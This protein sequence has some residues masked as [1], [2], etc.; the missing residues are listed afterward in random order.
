[1]RWDSESRS[2]IK[3]FTL[4]LLLSLLIISL[5]LNPN[6]QDYVNFSEETNGIKIRENV[7]VERINFYLFSTYSVQA[8]PYEHGIVH[9]G[10]MGNFFQI[11]NGQ[12]DY[13]SWLEFF[14]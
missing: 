10:F 12:Y 3:K 1:M 14:N 7:I 8:L 11:S 4:L 9:L 6:K 5:I 13:P 2:R